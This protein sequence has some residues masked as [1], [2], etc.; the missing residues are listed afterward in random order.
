MYYLERQMFLN[1]GAYFHLASDLKGQKSWGI[2]DFLVDDGKVVFR[3]A[4]ER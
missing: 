3:K 1:I 2:H 4:S